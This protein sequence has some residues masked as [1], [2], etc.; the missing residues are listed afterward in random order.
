MLSCRQLFPGLTLPPFVQSLVPRTAPPIA[1]RLVVILQDRYIAKKLP[2][3][4]AASA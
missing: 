3:Q 2:G 1:E 4:S